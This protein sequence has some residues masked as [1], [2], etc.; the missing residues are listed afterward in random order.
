MKRYLI[1]DPLYYTTNPETL[2]AKLKLT[3]IKYAPEF[4]CFRDKSGGDKTELLEAFK[5][6]SRTSNALFLI[7]GSIKN[8]IKFGF[9]GVHLQSSQFSLIKEAKQKN[10]TVIASCHNKGE[11]CHAFGEGC[12]F[13][14]LSPVFNSPNKG[15]PLGIEG[16][17]KELNGADKTKIFALGGIDNDEKVAQIEKTGVFGFASIRYFAI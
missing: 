15:E 17:E 2:E 3:L 13:A 12:D 1:T 4:V 11:L 9:C 10:L 16:F 7:N 8:A 6:T 14:T 5:K